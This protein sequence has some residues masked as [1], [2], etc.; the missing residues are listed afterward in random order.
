VTSLSDITDTCIVPSLNVN[1]LTS[2]MLPVGLS[3]TDA[4]NLQIGL[5]VSLLLLLPIHFIMLD[6]AFTRTITPLILSYVGSKIFSKYC[7]TIYD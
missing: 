3:T 2:V 5:I 1:H 7:S 6:F 4:W